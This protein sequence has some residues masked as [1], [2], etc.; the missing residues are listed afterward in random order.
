MGLFERIFRPRQNE[1]EREATAEGSM[2]KTLTAYRPHFTTW[3]GAI[4]ESDLVRAAI[5]AR[6]RH[7]SKLSVEVL[8]TA[9]PA[10]RARLR[11]GPNAWQTWSQFLYRLSTI[12]DVNTTAV[13]VPV[14]DRDMQTT[15]FFPVLPTR[16]ELV[17]YEGAEWLRYRFRSGEVGASPLS[18]TAILTRFQYASDFF[19][20]GNHALR[21]TM[22]LIHSQNEGIREAVENSATYRF[23]AK[24]TNF[25]KPE[26]LAK[27]RKRFTRENLSKDAEADNGVLLFPSTYADIK[28]IT[29][30]NYTIDAAQMD[31]IRTNVFCYF[32]VNEDV[33]QNKSFGD[34]WAAFY[35]GA[36]EPF[37]VQFSEAMTRAMFTERE[38]AQ[39]SYVMATANRLQYLSNADKLAV[40]A[41]MADRGLMSVNEIREI[42]NL[43]PVDG[44][45]ART[46]RGEYYTV[47]GDQEGQGENNGEE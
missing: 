12:L 10:L 32:G 1:A 43:P 42:W 44:G 21:S 33:L 9:R 34:A 40:S 11:Q 15:G 24:L 26:D 14:Y 23:T 4:Y 18:E 29:A 3:G 17:E 31:H 6:A 22:E 16:C 38:R 19:G 39:G 7:I 35:E 2:F 41:Q 46:I 28:Q 27:E 30:Q 37:A 5:D 36:V 20:E 47:G 13:I 8:G 25:A 45:D